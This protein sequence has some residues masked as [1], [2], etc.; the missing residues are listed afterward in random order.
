MGHMDEQVRTGLRRGFAGAVG[1]G[2]AASLT[3]A[4]GMAP[5][6][7][8]GGDDARAAADQL[9][10]FGY[11]GDVYGVKLVTDSV[12]ALNVKDAHAQ[13]LCTR[14][15]DRVVE[16]QSAVSVPDNP[17]IRVSASTSRTRTYVD[18]ATHGVR[19]TSTIGDISIGGTVGPL[20]TPRL[21][22]KGLE[23]TAHAFHTPQGFGHD[24]GFTFASISLELLDDTVV[25]QLPPELQQLLAPLDQVTDTVFT[26]TQQTA[27][28]VFQVLSDVT[29]PIV[30]PGLGSIALGYENGRANSHNA[31]SQASAL[32]IEVT[33][34]E[35]RQLVELG[36]ARVR[37]GGPAPV[38]VFRSGGTAMD[39]QVLDGA[40]RFGNVQ[41]KALP[42]QGTRGRTQTYQ[43]PHASQLLPVPVVL[44]GVTYQVNG[45]QLRRK[46]V[47]KGW[48][49]SAIRSVSIPTAQLVIT[50]VS[51]RVAMRQKAGKRVGSKVST[52]VGSITV[53]G[54]PVEVPAPGGVVELPNGAGEIQRQLVDTG[55]R[56]SQVIGLRIKLYSEA[57]VIDL[58]RTAGRIYPR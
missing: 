27:Q 53:G 58:A 41:H 37:M 3:L 10:K 17:L 33:A 9:T 29:K 54:Q 39:Y 36:T 49:R 44:D 14:A 22:I 24:E 21:V 12:E 18:G 35:R 46:K 1:I 50:D 45:D 13:Q 8:S 57:V 15:A 31:Q 34:G 48:S 51:S 47:A 16:Q 23:T 4:A 40:L 42:C 52:A 43:V 30:I 6:G 25:Q 26:G 11:R 55:F 2:L 19:G 32:R 20:T 5:A 7:A 56:G 28:E 38:G